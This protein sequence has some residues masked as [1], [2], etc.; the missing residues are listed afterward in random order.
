MK[1]KRIY[2]YLSED[3]RFIHITNKNYLE[4]IELGDLVKYEGVIYQVTYVYKY[5]N[6]NY[7]D[8][9]TKGLIFDSTKITAIY[10]PNEQDGYDLVW[11][12]EEE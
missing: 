5:A 12:K 3:K 10:K 6:S 7:Y 4:I 2:C 9:G 8:I 1:N 11:S